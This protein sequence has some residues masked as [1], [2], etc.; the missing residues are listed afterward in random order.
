MCLVVAVFCGSFALMAV[1]LGVDEAFEQDYCHARA[2]F[3]TGR[4]NR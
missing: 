4:N 1:A 2:M 3:S